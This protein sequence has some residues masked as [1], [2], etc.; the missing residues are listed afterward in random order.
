MTSN[1]KFEF[2]RI[3]V[4]AEPSFSPLPLSKFTYCKVIG[5]ITI[6]ARYY[7]ARF[8]AMQSDF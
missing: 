1:E 5:R 2:I 8:N 4:A 3:G 6:N 7:A